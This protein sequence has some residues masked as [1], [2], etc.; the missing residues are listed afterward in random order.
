MIKL[1]N[2]T[3][4]APLS[5]IYPHIEE[6]YRVAKRLANR[7]QQDLK[8]VPRLYYDIISIEANLSALKCYFDELIEKPDISDMLREAEDYKKEGQG[9][10]IKEGL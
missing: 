5:V 4:K 8:M 9:S 10:W 6:A 7:G 3:K 2:T 1:K